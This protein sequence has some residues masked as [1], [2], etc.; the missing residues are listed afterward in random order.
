MRQ[1]VVWN[2]FY[3]HVAKTKQTIC[4]I[5][6]NESESIVFEHEVDPFTALVFLNTVTLTRQIVGP[7]QPMGRRH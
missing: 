6:H 4:E 5:D 3:W 2:E 7:H 1:H